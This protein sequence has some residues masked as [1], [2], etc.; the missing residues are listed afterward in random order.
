[1]KV[2]LP[3]TILFFFLSFQLQAQVQYPKHSLKVGFGNSGFRSVDFQGKTRYLEYNRQL[4]NRFSIGL[5]GNWT[6]ANNLKTEDLKKSMNRLTGNTHLFFAPIQKQNTS[7][8]IGIGGSAYTSKYQFEDLSQELTKE[9]P[10]NYTAQDYGI[11][12]AVD[13]E[14]FVIKNWA[15]GTRASY[16][17][18]KN[19]DESYFWGFNTGIRF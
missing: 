1:M 15:L 14:I 16:Q 19:G 5:D 2:L 13:F 7:F 8:K 9:I 3:F 18:Y 12:V 11:S 6:Q 17:K 4:F 10:E